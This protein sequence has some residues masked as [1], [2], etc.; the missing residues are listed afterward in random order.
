MIENGSISRTFECREWLDVAK[1]TWPDFVTVLEI[2]NAIDL[3]VICKWAMRHNDYDILRSCI[4]QE[5]CRIKPVIISAMKNEDEYCLDIILSL[6]RP[7]LTRQILECIISVMLSETYYDIEEIKFENFKRKKPYY[8]ATFV[9]N[10]IRIYDLQIWDC[11]YDTL[12]CRAIRTEFEPL[13][14]LVSNCDYSNYKRDV[15]SLLSSGSYEQFQKYFPLY[16]K[17]SFWD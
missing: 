1:E 5:N 8:L 14:K 15:H 12:V 4:N 6:N 13:I 3:Y 9:V 17:P 10:R 7:I 16:K 11:E 2:N